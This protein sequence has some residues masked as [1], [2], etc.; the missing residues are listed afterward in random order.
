M[1]EPADQLLTLTARIVAAYVGAN[2]M[3]PG[4]VPG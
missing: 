4:K 2:A 3:D 1:P